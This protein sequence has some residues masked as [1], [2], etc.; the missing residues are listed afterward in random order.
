MHKVIEFS[1]MQN[2]AIFFVG[3]LE[4]F[5]LPNVNS[6]WQRIRQT[7]SRVFNIKRFINYASRVEISLRQ[8][9]FRIQEGY[10]VLLSACLP[11]FKV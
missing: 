11:A 2:T 4:Q 6:I 5:L 10:S 8:S 9:P 1:R 3:K 7:N